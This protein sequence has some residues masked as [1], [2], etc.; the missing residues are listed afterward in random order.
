M[1]GA[2]ARGRVLRALL[3]GARLS[4]G[5]FVPA[6][7]SAKRSAREQQTM[8][9]ATS[10]ALGALYAQ[11]K[12]PQIRLALHVR[13]D[14][15]PGFRRACLEALVDRFDEAPETLEVLRA[16]LVDGDPVV[17]VYAARVLRSDASL[18]VL[19]AVVAEPESPE[20]ALAEAL[21]GLADRSEA[22]PISRLAELPQLG[23]RVRAAIARGA[24]VRGGPAAEVLLLDLLDADDDVVDVAAAEALGR[25]GSLSAVEP[26]L[27][28][29]RGVFRD[30]AVKRAATAAVAA[31]QGRAGGES[32]GLSLSAGAD[33]GGLAVVGEEASEEPA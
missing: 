22:V 2:P 9:A 33:A 28:H 32:G 17:R 1:L 26:L 29:T 7:T 5:R 24:A 27:A 15:E 31:I 25:C 10:L 23:Q 4:G 20:D 12:T 19:R 6:D 18:E 11:G 3:A 21:F 16:A 13:T 30:R 8:D 14:P